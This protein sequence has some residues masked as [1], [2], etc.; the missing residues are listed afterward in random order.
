[1][2]RGFDKQW[3]EGVNIPWIEGSKSMD[4]RFD[5]SWVWGHNTMGIGVKILWVLESKYHG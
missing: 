4:K 3:V 5:I 1:M 2:G